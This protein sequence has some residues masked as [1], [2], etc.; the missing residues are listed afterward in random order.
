MKPIN[1][2]TDRTLA[3]NTYDNS[4]ISRS[5]DKFIKL[6]KALNSSHKKGIQLKPF[7]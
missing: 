2:N 3:L 1:L 7:L 4:Q 6:R 5:D